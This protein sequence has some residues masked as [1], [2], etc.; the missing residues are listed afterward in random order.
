VILTVAIFSFVMAFAVLYFIKMYLT[1]NKINRA[2]TFFHLLLSESIRSHRWK[3]PSSLQN[4][5]FVE[6]DKNYNYLAYPPLYHYILALFPTRFHTRIA[7]S[8]SLILLSLISSLAAI[9]TYNLTYDIGLAMLSSFIV[10]FNYAA[11]DLVTQSSPRPLGIFF[12]S[13]I[14]CVTVFLPESLFSLIAITILVAV[15]SLTHKFAVQTLVFGFLPYAFIFFKPYFLLSIVF[16]FLLSILISKGFYLRILKEQVNWLRFYR[17]RPDRNRIIIKF[18]TIVGRNSWFLLIAV[19][20]LFVSI[21]SYSNIC[22]SLLGIDFVTKLVFW[23]LVNILI[24]LLVS[25]PALSFLGE[26]YRYVEY[27]LVP[28]AVLSSIFLAKLS[29]NFS[30][31]LVVCIPLSLV[32]LFKFRKYL[33]RSKALTDPNDILSYGCLRDY[34]INNLLV[35][36]TNRTLEVGYYSGLKIIHLVRGPKTATEHIANLLNNYEI[37]YILKFKD[38]DCYQ[39]F[40]TMVNMT[41]M[42]KIADFTNFELY[43]KQMITE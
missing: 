18:K 36:P 40:A 27:S 43:K 4:V 22:E 21:Q 33:D 8:Y 7:K 24:A 35:F 3:F 16:G 37:T 32:A 5:I 29:S 42:K 31:L 11:F 23:A 26:Y 17:D 41:N 38:E 1:R 9:L 19:S 25:F 12:Y 20:I 39:L 10:I 14:V 30:L 28:I 13:L 2:D 34:S 15:V 6:M